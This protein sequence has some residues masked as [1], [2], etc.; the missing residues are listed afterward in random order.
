MNN[1]NYSTVQT[2]NF[3]TLVPI[4]VLVLAHFKVIATP[5]DVTTI[6]TSLI[7]LVGVI[8]SMWR[9]YLQGD[10]TITGKRIPMGEIGV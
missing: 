5:D 7:A 10:I 2:A 4:I 3:V 9:R 1:M 8:V 6:V